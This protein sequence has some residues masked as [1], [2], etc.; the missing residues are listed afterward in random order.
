M[1]SFHDVTGM[2]PCPDLSPNQLAFRIAFGTETTLICKENMT[3]LMQCP[4]CVLIA[5]PQTVPPMDNFQ[6]DAA[7]RT[8]GE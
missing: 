8:A 7:F 3:P 4:V 1:V 6:R 2:Q 5:P